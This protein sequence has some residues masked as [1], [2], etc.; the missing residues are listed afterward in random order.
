MIRDLSNEIKWKHFFDNIPDDEIKA[1]DFDY[2]RDVVLK[3]GW[4]YQN[5]DIDRIRK[6]K[7]LGPY[8]KK[9]K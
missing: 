4:V 1:N 3:N 6:I 7:E 8:S 9:K 2:L 5:V